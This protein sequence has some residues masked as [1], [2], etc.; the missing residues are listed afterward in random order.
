MANKTHGERRDAYQELTDAIVRQLEAGTP[1]WR[2]PWNAEAA[3]MSGPVNPTTGKAGSGGRK[4]RGINIVTL[5]LSPLAWQTGDPR[6]CSFRQGLANGWAVRKGERGLPVFFFKKLQVRDKN[7]RTDAN[8]DPA[9]AFVPVMRSSTAF[10]ISQFDPMDGAVIPPYVPPDRATCPWRAPAAVEVIIANSGIPVIEGGER[11]AYSPTADRILLPPKSSFLD[12]DGWS[13][14]V[15]HE[16][17]HAVGH[18][19]RCCRD[20][21]GRFGS[22]SY[23]AEELIAELGSVFACA[24]LGINPDLPQHASYL[25]SFLDLL[26]SDKRAIFTAAARASEASD[27]VLSWHP[28]YKTAADAERAERVGEDAA[29]DDGDRHAAESPGCPSDGTG[30]VDAGERPGKP[31]RHFDADGQLATITVPFLAGDRVR[32]DGGHV[33]VVVGHLR[34]GQSVEVQWTGGRTDIVPARGLVEISPDVSPPFPSPIQPDP[35]L[36]ARLSRL[37]AAGPE[38]KPAAGYQLALF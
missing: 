13:A 37:D 27:H 33:G 32:D 17:C 30:T 2:R 3:R 11:A 7:G 36:A 29:G 38:R 25:A 24:E 6:F 20:L 28:D 4:Y 12:A 31:Y 23:A 18:V 16:L 19:S 1:P 8:G 26:K 14:T 10:H 35:S 22:K 21:T 15:L 5:G 34:Q 9:T